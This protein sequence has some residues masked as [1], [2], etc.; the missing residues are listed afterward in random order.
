MDGLWTAGEAQH[1][2]RQAALTRHRFLFFNLDPA[3]ALTAT[4]DASSY[5]SVAPMDIPAG[6]RTAVGLEG[7]PHFI[8][9]PETPDGRPTLGFEWALVGPDAWPVAA[10]LG[11][12][13]TVTIWV[14]AFNTMDPIGGLVPQWLAFE[15]ITGVEYNQLYHSFDTNVAGLRWQIEN[16]EP[17]P[18]LGG[19]SVGLLFAEL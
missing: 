4:W 19:T 7:G 11:G 8:M 17:G 3:G 9:S 6:T 5:G 10:P 16:Y 12:G 14:L 18:G 1:P 15:P 13:F 2:I